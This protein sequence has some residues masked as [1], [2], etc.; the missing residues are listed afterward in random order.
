MND[1]VILA[2][3]DVLGMIGLLLVG[4]SFG[5]NNGWAA[6]VNAFVEQLKK[7]EEKEE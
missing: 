2:I 1:N 3:A 5:Y 7:S 6:G 4:Y